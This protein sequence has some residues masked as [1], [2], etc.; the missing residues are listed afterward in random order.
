MSEQKSFF[1]TLPGIFTGLAALVTAVGGLVITLQQTGLLGS[2]D[3]IDGRPAAIE[4]ASQDQPARPAVNEPAAVPPAKVPAPTAPA[5]RPPLR[6]RPASTS[7]TRE[8]AA[9]P[10]VASATTTDGWAII[11]NYRDGR[12]SDLT[13]T[14][15]GDSPAIGRSYH[16][17]ADFRLVQKQPQAGEAV[18][19]LG[20]V[21]RGE[22]VEV[23]DL[24]VPVPVDGRRS[25]PVWAKL[26]AVLHPV[27]PPRDNR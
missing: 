3:R 13:L 15:D 20:M 23:V 14:V 26:R 18:L 6:P 24:V 22:P 25:A 16:A 19:T 21:H 1:T 7:P 5:P 12:F 9:V 17:V 4:S 8:P 10:V 27:R 2:G 11:G